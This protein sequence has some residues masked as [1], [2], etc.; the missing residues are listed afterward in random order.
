MAIL[1]HDILGEGPPLLL[2]HAY[3]FDG[4]FWHEQRE[5]LSRVARLII[6]DLRGFGC[7]A[8][9]SPVDSLEAHAADLAAL[10]DHHQIDK[11]VLCGVSMGGYI[12]L[13]FLEQW[14][15]R[16]AGLVLGH[17]RSQADTDEG[18][19]T[20][21]K[22]AQQVT[23]EGVAAVTLGLPEKMISGATQANQPNLVGRLRELMLDQM[24]EALAAAQR[25]MAARPDRTS[26]L[27]GLRAPA[28][29]L[30]GDD[31]PLIP[32]ADIEAMAAAIPQGRLVVMA[33]TAHLSNIERPA[34]FN[35]ELANFLRA[36]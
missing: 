16:V 32:R 36:G 8:P 26:I 5:E 10:L 21:L 15:A 23:A 27:A 3:P 9:L 17:T 2:I 25:A 20:R 24:P 11:A 1:A 6:P 7:S 28:L 22:S 33:D 34:A 31:D 19:A 29:V 13:A 4:R 35:G 18:R 12:A 14:P 30:A